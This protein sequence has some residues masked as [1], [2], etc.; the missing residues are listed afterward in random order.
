MSAVF[1]FVLSIN[2]LLQWLYTIYGSGYILHVHALSSYL[3]LVAG[4]F[5]ELVLVSPGAVLYARQS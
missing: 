4:Y 2:Q 1:E 3:T 5:T